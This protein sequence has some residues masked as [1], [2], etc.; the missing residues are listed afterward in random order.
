MV[1]KEKA[2]KPTFADKFPSLKSNVLANAI[3]FGRQLRCQKS[4]S[5]HAAHYIISVFS[6]PRQVSPLF[7]FA[8]MHV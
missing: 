8:K 6:S 1:P 5:L 7:N 2:G 4:A 3:L